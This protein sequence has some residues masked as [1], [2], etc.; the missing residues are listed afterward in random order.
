MAENNSV[1]HRTVSFFYIFTEPTAAEATEELK[2]TQLA[3]YSP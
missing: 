3:K 2:L 1:V